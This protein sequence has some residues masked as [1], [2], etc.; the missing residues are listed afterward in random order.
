MKNS[1]F[2]FNFFI[3]LFFY[4]FIFEN[5]LL[6][7]SSKGT[8]SKKPSFPSPTWPKPSIREI[9]S[10]KVSCHSQR[11]QRNEEFMIRNFKKLI[12]LKLAKKRLFTIHEEIQEG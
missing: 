4:F 6:Q 1:L 11:G 3:F 10:A 2:F 7:N 5:A 9:Q 8:L 12:Q